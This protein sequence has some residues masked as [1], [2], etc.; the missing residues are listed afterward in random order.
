MNKKRKRI[1]ISIIVVLIILLTGGLI[2]GAN[3]LVDYAIGRNSNSNERNVVAV[4]DNQALE[5]VM[6]DNK[7]K[8][9]QAVSEW[10]QAHQFSEITTTSTDGLK[11]SA[12]MYKQPTPTNKWVILV[13]GYKETNQSMKDA[14]VVFINHGYNVLL[15]DN[16]GCGKS[17]GQWL[18]MGWLDKEDIKCWINEVAKLT[19]DPSIIMYGRSMGGA[20]TMMLS[21]DNPQYVDLYIEE[22]G[23]TS[24]YDIFSSELNK[25]FNLPPFP[26]MDI[27]NIIAQFKAGYNFK[28]ASSVNQVKKCNKPMLFIHGTEDNFVSFSNLDI[29]YNAKKGVK[30]KMV[31]EGAN[32]SGSRLVD[33]QTYWTTIFNFINNNLNQ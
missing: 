29:V 23:Y 6:A 1:I 27:G 25:R 12:L 30:E 19:P 22:C 21:G 8:Y 14:A 32:H 7:E 26:L 2:F 18:G 13:H 5:Q 33:P 16:R 3:Y 20:T 24:A 15:P 10:E 28:E 17:E 11:L 4:N 9:Q 31:V